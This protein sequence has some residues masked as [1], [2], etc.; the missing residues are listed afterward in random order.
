[1]L[2]RMLGAARLSVDTYEDVEHD[3]GATIQ[4]LLVVVIVTIASVVGELLRGGEAEV[5]SALVAGIIRG[6]ASWALWALLTWIVGT[7]I[8]KTEGTEA[9]WGQLARGT[10]F[11]QTPGILQV[12]YFIPAV[13]GVIS[14]LAYLWTFAAMVVAVRQSL[15]YTSTLRAFFVIL[16]AAIPVFVINVVVIALTGGLD[17]AA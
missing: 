2:A 11:A 10:G 14:F 3:N 9:D 7:T 15:D 1:M 17:Q 13:G 5:A 16:I 8:L 4:A 6:V 12:L